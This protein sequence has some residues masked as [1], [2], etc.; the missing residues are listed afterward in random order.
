MI[1]RRPFF[2]IGGLTVAASGWASKL[3]GASPQADGSPLSNMVA[4]VKPLTAEDFVARL[5][6]ACWSDGNSG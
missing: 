1:T 2:K 4:D 3:L 6:K 5:G